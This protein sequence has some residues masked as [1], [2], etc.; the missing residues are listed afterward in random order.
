VLA[1]TD[2]RVADALRLHRGAPYLSV[3][4][5]RRATAPSADE[6]GGSEQNEQNEQNE[7][8]AADLLYTAVYDA[9]GTAFD[10]RVVHAIRRPRRVLRGQRD[11][12]A[13]DDA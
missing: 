1:Q 11:I 8:N 10:G 2:A 13:Y 6:S 4:R 5:V 9:T 7:H 12:A 3:R